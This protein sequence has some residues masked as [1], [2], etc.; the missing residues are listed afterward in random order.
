MQRSDPAGAR[1]AT[2]KSVSLRTSTHSLTF[3]A[4]DSGETGARA[5]PYYILEHK[6]KVGFVSSTDLTIEDKLVIRQDDGSSGELTLTLRGENIGTVDQAAV[7]ELAEFVAGWRSALAQLEEKMH[8]KQVHEFDDPLNSDYM[9]SRLAQERDLYVEER[10]IQVR[11]VTWN[12]HGDAITEP[13]DRLF[14]GAGARPALYVFGLQEADPLTPAT[15]ST[16]RATLDRWK[17]AMLDALGP[18]YVVAASSELLGMILLLV[19]EQDI[20]SQMSDMEMSTAGTGVLGYWGNKGGV[21]LR[22]NLAR[23]PAADMA[24][25]EIGIVNMHLSAGNAAGSV[26]RRKWEV[27]ELDRRLNLPVFNGRLFRKQRNGGKNRN[28][29]LFENGDLLDE[30]DERNLL[31]DVDEDD[32]GAAGGPTRRTKLAR[33]LSRAINTASS[34]ASGATDADG[35]SSATF[36][37]A[38]ST[39]SSTSAVTL[40]N[41][42]VGPEK[43]INAI[44]FA[45][46]DLNYRLSMDRDEIIKQ[47]DKRN[48]DQLLSWDQLRHEMKEGT[49]FVGFVEGDVAFAPSY[50]YDLGGH[51]FD[52]SE[53]KRAPAYTDRIL[54]TPYPS[55]SQLEYRSHMGFVQ[56][57]HKP[58]VSTFALR[59]ELINFDKRA[60]IVKNLLH[61]MDSKENAS[62]PR[63]DVEKTE[64][65]CADLR[66][67]EVVE[68]SLK[69]KNTGTTP[70]SWEIVLLENARLRFMTSAG[71]L[72][73]GATQYIHFS[74]TAEP[75]M[76]DLSEIFILR[77]HN[78]Q[79]Y[80]ISVIAN[81]LPSCFGAS[82]D[83]LVHKPAGMR[84]PETSPTPVAS[85]PR[86]LWKCVDYLGSRIV[87][88][89]F[90]VAGDE[91]LGKLVREWLDN[92]ED[93]EVQ[94]LDSM[95][96]SRGVHAVAEQL[97]MFLRLLEDG[98]VP[99]TAYAVVAKGRAGVP[100]ILEALPRV[101]ANALIYVSSFVREVVQ[102]GAD[103][104]AIVA[105]F[106]E[107][108]VRTPADQRRS[109]R[110]RARRREFLRALIMA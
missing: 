33:R 10:T 75:R 25:V 67:M 19:A 63:V 29:L 20:A 49:L 66:V 98:V 90:Q 28:E 78:A 52:S 1:H 105:I 7:S 65:V 50:K 14:E 37:S 74:F 88:N 59:L 23:N 6:D 69:F 60:A 92:G 54:Y 22:F 38:V 99:E 70:V 3:F 108:L 26:E 18:T 55:L 68:E 109:S 77:I 32:E 17:K 30:L 100:A 12:L 81:V 51:V 11:L 104:D 95:P 94:L 31:P 110:A 102:K 107:A 21:S 5:I 13:L 47:V 72:L 40:N 82:V 101:N 97:L 46:G 16:N 48:Y 80:F 34:A 73:P 27:S 86:E 4:A 44:V 87:P 8:L 64:V 106:D 35:S 41:D 42:N 39:T 58:V 62:R 89:V 53:K 103:L 56:S 2:M 36:S 24:G 61:E 96:E 9:A 71:R 84:S 76:L 43:D 83:E 15:L 93:F 57:D 85:V 45:L 79:D 91:M